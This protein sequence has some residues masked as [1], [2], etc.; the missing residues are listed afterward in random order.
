[1]W[2]H[3]PLLLEAVTNFYFRRRPPI[4]QV[5]KVLTRATGFSLSPKNLHIERL[6]PHT[7]WPLAE[8]ENTD[9]APPWVKKSIFGILGYVKSDP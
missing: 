3:R 2:T 7:W 5:S 8:L 1:M 4:K 6:L 9:A